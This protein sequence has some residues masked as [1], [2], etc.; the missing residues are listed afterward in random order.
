M[1]EESGNIYRKLLKT[2]LISLPVEHHFENTP[3]QDKMG[4]L[5]NKIPASTSWLSILF[6]DHILQIPGKF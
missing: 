4:E 5:I 3:E 6:I 2:K 1:E